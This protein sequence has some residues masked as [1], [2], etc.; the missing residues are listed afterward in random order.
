[1][2]YSLLKNR[3]YLTLL[4]F[5][6]GQELPSYVQ[7]GKENGISRQTA[8][9]RVKT[10]IKDNLIIIWEDKT[11]TVKNPLNLNIDILKE[12][13]NSGETFNAIELKEKMFQE[14]RTKTELAEEL[15]VSRSSLSMDQHTVV[16]GICSEGKIKYIGTSKHFEDRIKQHIKN[17]PFLTAA[18][19]IILADN[20]IDN[21]FYIE[22]QLIDI[23]QP[24]W[25]ILGK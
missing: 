9:A 20:I 17:R 10:L 2:D 8:S 24:E 21:N 13:L 3:L 15:Q 19:F 7:L 1:M 18:N 6:D 23:L 22:N 11:I 12:Y 4:A 14:K 16:Y 25:N 5:Y